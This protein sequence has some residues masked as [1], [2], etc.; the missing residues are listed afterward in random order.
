[1]TTSSHSGNR[2]LQDVLQYHLRSEVQQ[3]IDQSA[4]H[5]SPESA[6]GLNDVVLPLRERGIPEHAIHLLRLVPIVHVAWA[7]GTVR[8][9]HRGEV[10]RVA[11]EH[12]IHQ[13]MVAYKL[14]EIWLRARPDASLYKVWSDYVGAIRWI[15]S[16]ETFQTLRETSV[17]RGQA[18]ANAMRPCFGLTCQG[19]QHETA[20]RQISMAFESGFP[21]DR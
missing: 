2:S 18:T 8:A 5:A 1:M 14:L 20:I 3:E 17:A 7:D 10:L 15:M 16:E 9:S 19:K 13:G 11:R 4:S 21:P 6:S 12:G